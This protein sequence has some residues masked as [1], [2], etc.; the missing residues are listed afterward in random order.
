[1]KT[2]F[3]LLDE[4]APYGNHF[5]YPLQEEVYAIIGAC[6]DV[7]TE[8]GQGFLEVIYKDALEIELTARNIPFEREKMFTVFY[9]GKELKRKY[10]ADF[11]VY[12][13]IVLEVKAQE[14]IIDQ[15]Y[16]QTLNYLAACK[17]PLAVLVNFGEAALKW[18]RL[19]LTNKAN[20]QFNQ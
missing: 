6:M 15:L 7:H 14:G 4:A 3:L 8:L 18:K 5:E 9:K 11:F 19:I 20:K 1:M 16:P 10:F 12:D 17:Q 2:N 13:Q